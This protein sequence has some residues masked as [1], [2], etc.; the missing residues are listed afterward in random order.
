MMAAPQDPKL[1]MM[2][3]TNLLMM[4]TQMVTLTNEVFDGDSKNESSACIGSESGEYRR[5]NVLAFQM[6]ETEI[7][8]N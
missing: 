2:M 6:K 8:A 1:K 4:M 7:A 3:I 5:M